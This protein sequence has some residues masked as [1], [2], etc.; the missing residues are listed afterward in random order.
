MLDFLLVYVDLHFDVNGL[1]STKNVILIRDIR[2]IKEL[3]AVYS[4]ANYSK[5]QFG[6]TCYCEIT[7]FATTLYC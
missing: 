7:S 3:A 1:D 4:Y 2:R 6:T 5:I